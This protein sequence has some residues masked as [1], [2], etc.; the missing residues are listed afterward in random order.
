MGLL[1]NGEFSDNR[2][3]CGRS[4]RC[5]L[6]L[7]LPEEGLPGLFAKRIGSRRRRIASCE[8][9]LSQGWL[10]RTQLRQVHGTRLAAS[11]S[12]ERTDA[13][14]RPPSNVFEG[15]R[16]QGRSPM[17]GGKKMLHPAWKRAK[18][19]IWG[20]VV[21]LVSLVSGQKLKQ[22]ILSGNKEKFFH[23]WDNQAV[24]QPK[25][26]V[27]SLSIKV[28]EVDKKLSHPI[29]PCFEQHVSLDDFLRSLPD[30]K[31]GFWFTSSK[32]RYL[33]K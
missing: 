29:W 21:W 14:K 12:T 13:L 32:T 2:H 15:H 30:F 9:G 10:E 16:D 22:E 20:A 28:F 6:F 26:V 24:E 3:R 7:S 4:T 25:E 33:R 18:K 5:L 31:R 19:I 11:K 1:L 17:M 8:R 27:L 23:P